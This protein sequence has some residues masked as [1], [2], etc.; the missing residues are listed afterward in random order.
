MFSKEV[1]YLFPCI[2]PSVLLQL[3]NLWNIGHKYLNALIFVITLFC[4]S[5]SPL[6]FFSSGILS[7][8]DLFLTSI[9]CIHFDNSSH[10]ACFTLLPLSNL[11]DRKI[12]VNLHRSNKQYSGSKHFG[13]SSFLGFNTDKSPNAGLWEF[14]YAKHA[15]SW[16]FSQNFSH[17]RLWEI[18]RYFLRFITCLSDRW[19]SGILFRR[20]IYPA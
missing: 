4:L 7:S 18:I 15:F 12:F 2:V 8:P 16:R 3:H 10:T 17:L 5:R 20:R 11:I 13:F 19:I 1:C 9:A 6:S 14:L